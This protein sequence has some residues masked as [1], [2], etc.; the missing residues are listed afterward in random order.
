MIDPLLN[1]K[2]EQVLAAN[3]AAGRTVAL[4][5]SC[6]GGMVCAALTDIAGSSDV[7]TQGFVTYAD[8]AKVRTLDVAQDILDTFGAVSL[9]CAWAMASGALAKSG[10]DIAV[11]ITGIAGPGGGSARKPVGLVAFARARKGQA[12]DLYFT[13]RV[14]FESTDRA[15]IRRAATAYA[16]D[17]LHPDADD[18][19]SGDDIELP[20]P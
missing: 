4:A 9:A 14:Q 11:S 15:A 7:L 13:Q 1:A 18:W 2:A 5:E 3:R 12:S 20:A 19:S 17:M 16:L 8:A 6:T 10:A